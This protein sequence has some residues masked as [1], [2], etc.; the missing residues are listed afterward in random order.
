MTHRIWAC[1]MGVLIACVAVARAQ[2][3]AALELHLDFESDQA[4]DESGNGRDGAVVGG[5]SV[6]PGVVGDAWDFDGSVQIGLNDQIFK[7]PDAELSIRVWLLPSDLDTMRTIYDEGGAWTGFTVRVMDGALEFA[8]VC[9]DAAHPP[10]EIISVD[11]T[12]DDDWAEVTAVF[13]QGKMLLYVNGALVGEQ[14]T[15]WPE[16]GAHGQAGVIGNVDGDSAFGGGTGFYLGLMDEFRVYSRMLDAEELSLSVSP[17]ASDVVTT[18]G[19]LRR[20]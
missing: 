7:D 6:V 12:E 17:G 16:L 19:R 10:P 3:D 1:C 9:C 2:G 18:W 4:T 13:G 14:P 20:R 5:P 8:T 11:Y 15:D